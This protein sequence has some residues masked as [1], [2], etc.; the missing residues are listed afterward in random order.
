VTTSNGQIADRVEGLVEARN[1]R[2]IRV[3]GEWRN[4]SKF[5]PLELPG[6]GA[7]VRL[8]L[9]SKG[10]IRTLQILDEAPSARLG[11]SRQHDHTAVCAQDRSQLPRP[12]V[13]EEV[14]SDHVL[15]LAEK[16]LEWVEQEELTND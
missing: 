5:H 16:W 15:V 8:E 9:D 12:Q 3:R 1:E 2:G 11:D 6:Q 4:L 13:H 10:F 7:R 14:K